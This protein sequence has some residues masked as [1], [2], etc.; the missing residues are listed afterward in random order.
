MQESFI[1]EG[2]L[3]QSQFQGPARWDSVH[4]PLNPLE[5]RLL[6]SYVVTLHLAWASWE[7]EVSCSQLLA[8]S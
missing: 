6:E 2:Y 3:A 7:E 5:K 4:N 1:K 8:F